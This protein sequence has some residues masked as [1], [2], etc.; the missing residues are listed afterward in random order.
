MKSGFYYTTPERKKSIKNLKILFKPKITIKWPKNAIIIITRIF[1]FFRVFGPY[2]PRFGPYRPRFVHSQVLKQQNTGRQ[3][4]KRTDQHLRRIPTP[5]FHVTYSYL[6][7]S[8]TTL[9]I[10]EKH[11]EKSWK[12]M[13]KHGQNNYGIFCPFYGE[14]I[15]K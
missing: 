7:E 13:E 6:S 1:G 3:R 10:M 9:K 11:M 2:R 4:P 14:I 5:I 12:I 8:E 15:F